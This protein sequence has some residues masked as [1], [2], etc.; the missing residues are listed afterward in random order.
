VRTSLEALANGIFGRLAA[1]DALYGLLDRAARRAAF[2]RARDGEAR[3]RI[4]AATVRL[5]EALLVRHG[6]FA[7]MKYPEAASVGS[8]L[9]PK[10]LGSYERELTSRIES[11]CAQPV[12]EIVDVGCA[13]GYYAVG[14]A[15]RISAA[16]VWAFDTDPRAIDL[17]HRMAELNG[18]RDRLTLGGFCSPE[19]IA[20]LPLTTRPLIISD[21]EGYEAKLFT[22]SLMP[23]LQRCELLIE[24]HD[25]LDLTIS[26][27]LRERFAA[28]HH[29]DV[30]ASVDDN[31]KAQ[32]YDFP[33]LTGCDLPTRRAILAEQRPAIMEWLH[34]T[35]RR[36]V[37]STM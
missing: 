5:H 1:S 36:A 15:M 19:T 9:A 37:G 33:E 35:P 14:L 26:S 16:R 2:L 29:V 24:T 7:G 27:G 17:C 18:V 3:E 31:K 12:T 30:I 10:L 4:D 22:D 21:C 28:T 32:T 13:E 11:I 34:L 8:Q 23:T 20:S 25:F 6:P